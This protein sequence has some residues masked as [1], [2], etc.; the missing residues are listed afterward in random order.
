M[1]IGR[2]IPAPL[3]EK[4]RLWRNQARSAAIRR[5]FPF[6]S[7]QLV[8][9]LRSLGIRPGDTVLAHTS[10]AR[11]EGFTGGTSE[12]PLAQVRPAIQALQTAVGEQ[13]SLLLPTLPFLGTALEYVQSGR[14]T[15]INRTPSQ[16]GL[17][18]EIFR[19]LP[20][21]TR[22]IHPTHPV[23][24][25][26]NRATEL[27]ANHYKALTP[28]GRNS[29]FHR[30]LEVDGKILLAGVDFR[31][32][33]FFHYVEELLEPEMPFSPFTS[34]WFDLETR[35]PDGRTYRTRTRLYDPAVSSIRDVR[36]M[37]GPL[38]HAGFWHEGTVGRLNLIVLS[39]AEVLA[40]LQAMSKDGKYCYVGHQLGARLLKSDHTVRGD[41]HFS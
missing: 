26:G 25:W 9:T 13:G 4:L 33:T 22:S 7:N 36:L 19:R 27:T 30:L 1:S 31:T 24:A 39:A 2:H 5:F 37:I 6:N 10:L 20:G 17:L 35:G 21:V 11:F 28:C 12:G 18:T 41:V 16:M 15:D 34:E 3:K 14:L 40:T 23:A 29:P 38:R 32:M 8:N